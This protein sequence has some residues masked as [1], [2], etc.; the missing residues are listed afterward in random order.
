MKKRLNATQQACEELIAEI[1]TG[2]YPEGVALPTE[3]A[4]CERF[5]LSRMTIRVVL[6]RIMAAGLIYR[7]HGLGTFAYPQ[8]R[9]TVKPLAFLLREPS[10]ITSPYLNALLEGADRVARSRGAYLSLVSLPCGQWPANFTD[11]FSGVIVIP[12]D[13]EPGDVAE[14]KARG[15]PYMIVMESDL[16]GPTV[17]LDPRGAARALTEELLVRGHKR[18]ALLAGHNRHADRQKRLGIDEA[19][20][21]AGLDP[22][23][24]PVAFTGY[25]LDEAARG[26][27]DLLRL[28]PRPT[29]VIA[30]DDSLAAQFLLEARREKLVVPDQISLVGF[31][32][33]TF[34]ACLNPPLTTVRFPVHEAGEAAAEELLA[35]SAEGRAPADLRFD[36]ELIHRASVAAPGTKKNQSARIR[37]PKKSSHSGTGEAG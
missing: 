8:G 19:L 28:T 4:L 20:S 1:R 33:A 7:R 32:D 31:N 6:S 11:T 23:E 24:L 22:R 13:V 30:F 2:R 27:R 12:R 9:G 21:A 37:T 10:L 3:Y 35:A 26:A 29:A 5:G 18:L 16:P 15:L 14:L 34:S 25:E 17:R 36:Y